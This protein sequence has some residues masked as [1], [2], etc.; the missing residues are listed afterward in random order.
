MKRLALIAFLALQVVIVNVAFVH[1][2]A[3][4]DTNR[5]CFS[6]ENPA[7]TN[8]ISGTFKT[9]WERN[10]GLATFGYPL[11]KT[12]TERGPI[13]VQL[14][15][16]VR[17]ELR[18]EG[19][20][21]QLATLGDTLLQQQGR[22]WRAQPRSQPKPD[23]QYFEL[24]GRNLCEPF[25]S[26]Y[27]NHG[28]NPDPKR[29]TFSNAQNQ[30]L[31]GIPLTEVA[32]E[33]GP[34][35]K[36]YLMQWFQRARLEL[37]PEN[38]AETRVLPGRL[39]A[40]VMAV[41]PQ[42]QQT[43]LACVALPIS[44]GIQFIA[45]TCLRED[46]RFQTAFSLSGYKPN[47]LSGLWLVDSEGTTIGTQFDVADR[48]LCDLVAVTVSLSNIVRCSTWA[49]GELGH[50]SGIQLDMSD[51]Y[52]GRWTLA[53][54]SLSSDRNAVVFFEVLPRIIATTNPCSGA[55]DPVSATM[56]PTCAEGGDLFK[57]IGQGFTPG[58]KVSFFVTQ[59]DQIVEPFA[60]PYR[61]DTHA[62]ADGTITLIAQA[63]TRGL[64][65]DYFFTIEGQQSG[66]Q[67]IGGLRR[68]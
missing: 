42:N 48:Q 21:P 38:P 64:R 55:P 9:F 31:F 41:G 4:A 29:K 11:T 28:I 60:S 54:R 49:V 15:E 68:R 8:C 13:A 22:D 32:Q 39:G 53:M 3:A 45:E 19:Q 57:L 63:P 26:Y 10:G 46:N 67:A 1:A 23:C 25:L 59:P 34:D 47:E 62:W 14:F 35:G 12:T 30:A 66:H 17:M 51:L 61:Q 43:S 40:E 27:R 5:R 24:T 6:S 37:H 18:A 2:T 36:L 44:R 65:G 52:P 58:E 50:S 33:P 56:S 16:R 20:A 7:I